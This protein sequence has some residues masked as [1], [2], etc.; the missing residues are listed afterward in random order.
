[1]MKDPADTNLEPIDVDLHVQ[2]WDTETD[3]TFPGRG[4]RPATVAAWRESIRMMGI[5]RAH[6]IAIACAHLVKD[7][8]ADE[9]IARLQRYI[10][11]IEQSR[12]RASNTTDDVL[13]LSYI[14]LRSKE[15]TYEEA[16]HLAS[17]M[18][19]KQVSPDAWRMRV[20]RW[21]A[22]EGKPKIEI[23]ERRASK[24]NK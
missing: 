5:D 12:A 6:E 22:K 10:E 16:A 1:M 23:Y 13:F 14:R 20:N 8:L 2:Y 21:A 18:L 9:D 17:I 4:L 3:A 15:I 7:E 11:I 19:K 24:T